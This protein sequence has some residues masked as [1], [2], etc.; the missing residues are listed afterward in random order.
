MFQNGN[1]VRVSDGGAVYWSLQ[2]REGGEGRLF[3]GLQYLGMTLEVPPI[4]VQLTRGRVTVKRGRA[5]AAQP[6]PLS[7]SH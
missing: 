2:D 4:R 5:W 6:H 7:D 1:L 3:P